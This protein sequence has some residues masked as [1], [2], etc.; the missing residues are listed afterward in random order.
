[1]SDSMMANFLWMTPNL[2]LPRADYLNAPSWHA[3]ILIF[4]VSHA[5][6][7]MVLDTL[8]LFEISHAAEHVSRPLTRDDLMADSISGLSLSDK[9]G[10]FFCF[11]YPK[12]PSWH[13]FIRTSSRSIV[14]PTSAGSAFSFAAMLWAS[15]QD[16]VFLNIFSLILAAIRSFNFAPCLFR[17]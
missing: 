4:I 9:A 1:M 2:D 7:T 11:S 14:V 3:D 10:I 13:L 12:R 17:A 8:N 15:A 5:A 6:A 16:I